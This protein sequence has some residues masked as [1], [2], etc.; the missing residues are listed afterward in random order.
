MEEEIMNN[1]K[2]VEKP[3]DSDD[4]VE[5]PYSEGVVLK[6]RKDKLKGLL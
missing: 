4:W 2:V 1:Q 3:Q 5:V 6:V